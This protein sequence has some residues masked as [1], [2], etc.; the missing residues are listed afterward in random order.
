MRDLIGLRARLLLPLPDC[1]EVF[2][3]KHGFVFH[4]RVTIVSRCLDSKCKL[5]AQHDGTFGNF[6]RLTLCRA[7]DE[8]AMHDG[9]AEP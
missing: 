1:D 8:T 7:R 3:E 6:N 2:E 9:D 5:R 4:D